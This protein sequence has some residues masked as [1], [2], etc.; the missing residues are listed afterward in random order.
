MTILWIAAAFLSGS[1]MY[2]YWIGLSLRKNLKNI[3]DGNPG[4][5]N[6]GR[7][8]G[9]PYAIL[10][11]ALDF[12]KGYLPLLFLQS[13]GYD[14]HSGIVFIAA[15]PMIGHAFSPFLRFKGG[16][17]IAVTF[18]V[19]SAL[20]QFEISVVYAVVLAILMLIAKMIRIEKLTVSE[21]DG[22]QVLLG[23]LFVFIYMNNRSFGNEMIWIWLI[24]FLLLVFTHRRELRNVLN[25]IRK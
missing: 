24:N 6:L 9:Y 10:G 12:L 18:G 1:F 20:T 2:S 21:S 4:A 14:P 15:A 5:I 16:K 17:S 13:S 23:M 11:T 8:A 22:L 19:W 7:A 25:K 3:G